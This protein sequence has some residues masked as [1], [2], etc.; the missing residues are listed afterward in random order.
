MTGK[1]PQIGFDVEFC[2]HF[3][4]QASR[5][6]ILRLGAKQDGILRKHMCMPDGSWRDT[7]VFSIIDGE[8]P[9]VRRHLAHL[10]AQGQGRVGAGA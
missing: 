8:W 1:K 7:A 10:M 6:A 2:T 9:A 4:N 3:M 5:A